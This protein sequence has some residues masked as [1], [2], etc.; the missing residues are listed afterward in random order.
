MELNNWMHYCEDPKS[1]RFVLCKINNL[2]E[3]GT[4]RY[5]VP[6]ESLYCLNTS[7]VGNLIYFTGG[8]TSA[9]EST[10]EQFFQITMRITIMPSMEIVID[11]LAN[12][13]TPRAN[14]AMET[15]NKH[16]L[17]VF[18]GT[19]S[20]GYLDSCEEYD[21]E[22]NNWKAIA[23]LNEKKKWMSVC[24]FN[25]KYLYSFGGCTS[26]K[27]EVSKSIECLDTT[28][29]LAKIWEIVKL[30]SGDDL[31]KSSFFIGTMNISNSYILL[32]GG[33]NK[34]E[35]E[36]GCMVFDPA[37]KALE[38][39]KG[40][41]KRDSFYRTK[42]GVSNK[43]YAIVGCRGGDLHVY[44]EETKKW[45]LMVKKIWNPKYEIAIKADTF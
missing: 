44:N 6:Y 24:A 8:G 45:G 20:S 38:K 25:N 14:H 43:Q 37:K 28:D 36:D 34:A 21:I 42:Y 2:K 31:V 4:W 30:I 3:V 40:L 5:N 19:N 7:Q 11:K 16:Y 22:T 17:Y 35:E 10:P 26:D 32:F 27:N 15:I 23:K 33:I 41:L 29:S 39:Q 12:M 9:S 18:G 1:N 13:L